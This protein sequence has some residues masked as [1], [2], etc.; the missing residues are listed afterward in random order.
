MEQWLNCWAS[1][2]LWGSTTSSCRHYTID[3]WS[4]L[5][6]YSLVAH[7]ELQVSAALNMFGTLSVWYHLLTVYSETYW[8]KI[9]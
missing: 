4:R 5:W 1:G 7:A 9:P 6:C 3:S 2:G 8:V